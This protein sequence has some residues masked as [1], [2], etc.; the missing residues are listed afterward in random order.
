MS[1]YPKPYRRVRKLKSIATLLLLLMA[2][3]CV[4]ASLYEHRWPELA[5]L[6]AFSEAATV[7]ALADWFAVTALFRHPL[8]LPIPHTAVI[9]ANKERIATN[10]GRFIQA[11]FLSGEIARKRINQI[12][13]A[14]WLSN[15]LQNPELSRQLSSRLS[16]ALGHFTYES[17][18]LSRSMLR[19][20]LDAVP[21]APACGQLLDLIFGGS[22]REAAVDAFVDGIRAT[23]IANRERMRR[24]L[25]HEL[26]W[27][28]PGFLHNQ[29]Y[30]RMSERFMLV[31][32]EALQNR[33]HPLRAM[34]AG[35]VGKLTE[36]L[37]HSKE[38]L[39]KGEALKSS[40][41]AERILD[42][43]AKQVAEALQSARVNRAG[44]LS[45]KVAFVLNYLGAAIAHSPAAQDKIN[46]VVEEAAAKILEDNGDA[47]AELITETVRTWDVS[48]LVTKFEMEIGADLQFIRVNGTLVGGAA[49]L[50]I[51]LIRTMIP[52]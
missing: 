23:G 3:L 40:P 33:S 36:R 20:V 2:S 43:L 44:V 42:D 7:G 39:D 1:D 46:A 35:E 9:P 16:D 17:E 37:K 15:A 38:L 24:L 48:T 27:Y 8:G 51:H 21:L 13:A 11:N 31:L 49:G 32:D 26:P 10:M 28:V 29:V 45:S 18:Q 47:I 5:W 25:R 41:I 6:R 34:L 30:E 50:V 19:S 12:N 14:R 52:G 4:F 22:K